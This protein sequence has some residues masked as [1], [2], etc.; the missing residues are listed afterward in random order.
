[1]R[2]RAHPRRR[3]QCEGAVAHL[4]HWFLFCAL[5]FYATLSADGLCCLDT[6]HN[7]A[8][9]AVDWALA[10]S[11]VS[12]RRFRVTGSFNNFYILRGDTITQLTSK[13]SAGLL[14]PPTQKHAKLSAFISWKAAF[15]KRPIFAIIPAHSTWVAAW[16]TPQNY[17]L[18]QR[19][20]T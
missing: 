19:S 9:F 2:T 5:R 11:S 10:I 6:R 13:K 8:F 15:R 18:R 12:W 7:L 4:P 17:A 14:R 3:M 16:Y 20:G 1:M